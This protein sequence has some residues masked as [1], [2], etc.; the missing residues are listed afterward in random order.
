MLEVREFTDLTDGD[1]T[2]AWDTLEASGACPN[3]FSSRVWVGVWAREFA[4]DST[5][6]VFVGYEDGAPVALAPLLPRP[7]GLVE[8]PTNF[9]S[10]RGEF[11]LADADTGPFVEEVLRRLRGDGRELGLRSVPADS[12]T[13]AELLGRSRAVGYLVNESE[14]RTSPY[15]E[16]AGS[17]DDYVAT[18]T[19]KRVA[20][21]RK[22]IR[23]I[24]KIE[25]MTVRRLDESSDVDALVDEFIDV[26]ARSWKERHGTSIQG[27]GLEAFY[28]DLCRALAEQGWLAPVWLER[29][30][31]MFAFVLAIVYGGA[32]Y[33]LKTSFD[34]KYKEF[35]PG[36]PLF[37]YAVTDAFERGL[38]KVDFLGE[39]SRWK[40]EWAT[41]HREHLNI[42][43]Y[44]S[45]VAGAM[46]HVRDTRVKPIAKKLLRRE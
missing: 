34:E 46:K 18:R 42:H 30:G 8:L 12:R 7:D 24:E 43:L 13:R 5:P 6:A 19:T 22:R 37:Y 10:L 4:P 20:R 28:H 29:D 35:S 45:D 40:S 44:P 17:W 39:P 16:I 21:W 36:T 32:M 3:P 33:G 41:G 15:L 23:K 26:E 27:R 14:S 25:G 11:L 38:S 9:L 1:L 31:R 2:S